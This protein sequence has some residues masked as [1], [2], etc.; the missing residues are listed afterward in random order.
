MN[1]PKAPITELKPVIK[2]FEACEML[3]MFRENHDVSIIAL[4]REL[5][6]SASYISDLELGRRKWNRE[7]FKLYVDTILRMTDHLVK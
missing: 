1:T 5:N 3:R 6:L 7:L 4:A 2:Q